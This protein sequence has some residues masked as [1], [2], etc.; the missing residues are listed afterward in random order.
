VCRF[1]HFGSRAERD[2]FKVLL[3]IRSTRVRNLIG[4][5]RQAREAPGTYDLCSCPDISL[6][7]ER[8][9]QRWNAYKIVN[10]HST[11]ATCV[12]NSVALVREQTIPTSFRRLSAKLMPTFE[13]RGCRVVS[14][15]DPCDRILGF[16]DRSRYF[17]FQVAPQL[18]SR[19]WVDP[20]PDP[21][22]LTKCGSAGNR[23]GDLWIYRQ[24]LWPLD[25]RSGHVICVQNFNFETWKK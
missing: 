11:F 2:D 6:A 18:Y 4:G 25:H 21:L 22:I 12:T 9:E 19:G 20:V 24:E 14:V 1:E 16:L 15:T 7:K 10:T 3:E 13:D 17:F 8:S 5:G 23:T